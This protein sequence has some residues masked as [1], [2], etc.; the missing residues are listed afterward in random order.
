MKSFGRKWLLVGICLL[1]LLGSAEALER[2]GRTLIGN[3]TVLSFP[4]SW[5]E[6]TEAVRFE[7]HSYVGIGAAVFMINNQGHV[8]RRFDLPGLVSGLD[9]DGGAVHAT[10]QGA[11]Y[12]ERFTL[13][14]EAPF[15]L[16]ERAVI[17]PQP[18]ISLWL[19]KTPLRLSA[20][21]LE[22]AAIQ[23]PDNPFL[24][25][26]AQTRLPKRNLSLAQINQILQKSSLTFP[27]WT[28]LAQQLDT[29][30]Y[31][32]SASIALEHA[33]RDAS[34]RGI[35]PALPVS[36]R[37]LEAYGNPSA[38]VGVLL[39]QN[40][41]ERADVWMRFL[42]E[43]YPRFEGYEALYAR[44]A[45]ILETQGRIGEA[46]EWRQLI[47]SLRRGSLYNLGEGDTVILRRGAVF[48][49]LVFSVALLAGLLTLSAQGWRQQGLDLKERGGR[50]I[51]LKRPVLGTRFHLLSYAS[52]SE[53]WTL[54]VLGTGLLL[55]LA[56]W[57]WVN[58]IGTELRA[59][60]LSM[61]TYGGGWYSAA[62]DQL[63]LRVSS[64]SALLS[65]LAAQLD[66]DEATARQIYNT[67]KH[68]C[69]L[70]N[71]GVLAALNDDQPQAT[72]HYRA[73][74]TLQPDLEAARYNLGLNASTPSAQ[75][76]AQFQR[77]YRQN[78]DP[79]NVYH[80][81]APRLCYPDRKT[82]ARAVAPQRTSEW[83]DW[84]LPQRGQAW[85]RL[86]WIR[87]AAAAWVAG[88][89]FLAL[90]PRPASTQQKISYSGLLLGLLLPGSSLLSHPWGG[91][92]LLCWSGLVVALIPPAARLV[93]L[94]GGNTVLFGF[95]LLT[96]IIG[97]IANTYLLTARRKKQNSP[98]TPP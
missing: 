90:I 12:V 73:A 54:V 87:L 41:L 1:G 21:E 52:F 20:Q 48:G 80:G 31:P 78:S 82:L 47:V 58:R 6:M 63:N 33:K 30:G 72:V 42:R 86:D 88:L 69:A 97:G 17:A 37:I 15:S 59:E 98:L 14:T 16:K 26:S 46:E 29:L 22:K 4:S 49:A 36:R 9:A 89:A 28:T 68:P 45:H 66:G 13:E 2:Q 93:G 92:L 50:W 64:E 71:L 95:L 10:I 55:C 44:Y 39:T 60:A 62:L 91:V 70:N 3:K 75:Y 53:R 27:A 23:F 25:L 40:K 79:R 38:Y 83:L 32:A 5:G 76:Q 8:V 43:L 85:Q 96:Y 35:D 57:Q 7:K 56:S 24:Q 94:G 61:G 18:E 74:L 34:L 77:R 11:G 65:G 84:A 19:T 81:T 67:L 51:G